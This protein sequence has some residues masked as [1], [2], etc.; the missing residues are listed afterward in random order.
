MDNSCKYVGENRKRIIMIFN[1]ELEMSILFREFLEKI[2]DTKNSAYI[3]EEFISPFGIP[4]YMIVEYENNSIKSIISFE[5]KLSSWKRGLA[6]AFKYKSFSNISFLVLDGDKKD[7]L[8][9]H[10]SNFKK[11]NIGLAVFNNKKEIDILFLPTIESPYSNLNTRKVV[12]KLEEDKLLSNINKTKSSN[13]ILYEK[14]IAL[15]TNTVTLTSF[16]NNVSNKQV[17]I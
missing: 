8:K 6:Q 9:K 4:D 5:L 2:Y 10:I 7:L 17:A 16:T 1:S 14:T 15:N 3:I 11:S 13:N 12:T